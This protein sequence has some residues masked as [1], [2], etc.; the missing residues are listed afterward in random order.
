MLAPIHIDE[1]EF[2][3]R[4]C[5]LPALPEVV[6]QLQGII[7]DDD[8]NVA[9][10]A[11]LISSDPAI[12]AQ[13]L[14]VA[15]SA[16]YGLP[17]EVTK[18]RMAVAF[19]GLNEIFRMVLALGVVNSMGIEQK[20]EFE[21]FWF[22]SFLTATCTKYLAKKYERLLSHDEL[23][24][25]AMLHDIGKLVYLK[26]FPDHYRELASFC[27][28]NGV[29]F[30]QSETHFDVPPSAHFGTLLCDHWRLPGQVRDACKFHTLEDLQS[31]RENGSPKPIQRI[32]CLGNLAAMLSA[33]P[34]TPDT[35][36][37]IRDA[38]M[39]ELACTESE[40]LTLMGDIYE[41]KAQLEGSLKV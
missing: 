5:T 10:V 8:V 18:V 3:R 2:L 26:F 21:Q 6:T 40:F 33:D 12:L 37:Q 16:Y 17:K 30:G 11:D 15:N 28:K 31:S 13:V 1:K 29:T 32:T 34:L 27:E 41:L 25:A 4:H 22:H 35:K 7:H 23:W 38:M 20:K 36:E 14:K 19:L 24:S 39:E 9:T